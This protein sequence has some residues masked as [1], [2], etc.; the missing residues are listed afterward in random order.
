MQSRKNYLEQQLAF[1]EVQ[2]ACLEAKANSLLPTERP[3][4]KVELVFATYT[5]QPMIQ[6][7]WT[8]SQIPHQPRINS[9][10]KARLGRLYSNCRYSISQV[11]Y[12]DSC[13]LLQP[14]EEK[15]NFLCGLTE[16]Y[17]QL[18]LVEATNNELSQVMLHS[19]RRTYKGLQMVSTSQ[20]VVVPV[21]EE[22]LTNKF[23]T[24]KNF[25]QRSIAGM[26]SSRP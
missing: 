11:V 1:R 7:D 17:F 22:R 4:N 6:G 21:L 18:S 5:Y 9:E 19:R 23:M 13:A 16:N 24:L 25:F 2:D 15:E 20:R 8:A 12:H 3:T 10:T 26:P 14:D